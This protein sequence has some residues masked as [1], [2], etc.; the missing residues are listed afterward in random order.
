LQFGIVSIGQLALR[1]LLIVVSK[2][3]A[4]YKTML[5]KQIRRGQIL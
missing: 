3:F 4:K 2:A 5:Q 1:G